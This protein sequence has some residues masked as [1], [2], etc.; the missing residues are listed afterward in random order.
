MKKPSEISVLALPRMYVSEHRNDKPEG[1]LRVY[2]MQ[3]GADPALYDSDVDRSASDVCQKHA[4]GI[5]GG[6]AVLPD[7]LVQLQVA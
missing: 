6:T 2:T 1:D 7:R 3:K 4:R 5:G